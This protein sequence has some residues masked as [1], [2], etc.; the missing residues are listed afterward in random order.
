MIGNSFE[1][2]ILKELYILTG[3]DSWRRNDN[4]CSDAPLSEW[5]GLKV[6]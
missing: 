4:W 6:L 3:G 2:D 1:R 5:Y